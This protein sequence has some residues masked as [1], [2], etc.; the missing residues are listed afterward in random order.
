MGDGFGNL[1]SVMRFYS[2]KV[3]R[4]YG[5]FVQVRLKGLTFLG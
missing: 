2:N 1:P 3:L 4:L 5:I